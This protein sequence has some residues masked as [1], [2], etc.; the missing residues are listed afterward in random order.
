MTHAAKER[1][2]GKKSTEVTPKRNKMKISL[3]MLLGKG[4]TTKK[5]NRKQQRLE[6]MWYIFDDATVSSIG[7]YLGSML[8]S[9]LYWGNIT[10]ETLVAVVG[11]GAGRLGID[12]EHGGEDGWV[13]VAT[14]FGEEALNALQDDNGNSGGKP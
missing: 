9:W 4:G 6:A 1:K 14:V 2:A 5:R 8:H 12:A 3:R 11:G 7:P 13:A 10:G